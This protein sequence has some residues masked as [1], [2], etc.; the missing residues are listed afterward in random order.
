MT[1]LEILKPA[2]EARENDLLGYQ[3][4]IDNYTLAIAKME[5][6][7][8]PELLDFCKNLKELLRTEKLEQ[9]KTKV[10]YDVIKQQLGL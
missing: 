2:L 6:E 10:I 3:I 5:A 4:N 1:K 8:D 7:N 9:K